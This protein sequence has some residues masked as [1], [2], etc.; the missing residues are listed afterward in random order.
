M[1]KNKKAVDLAQVDG[2]DRRIWLKIKKPSTLP[3]ST[4]VFALCTR[5]NFIRAR[6]HNEASPLNR[7][8]KKL[9]IS[10]FHLINTFHVKHMQ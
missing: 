2:H 6:N 8:N 1:T 9:H 10:L 7:Q 4:A 3:K 5:H